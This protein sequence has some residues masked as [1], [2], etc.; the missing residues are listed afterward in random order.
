MAHYEQQQFCTKIRDSFPSYF[1]KK[2]VLDIG[3]LDINGNNRFL[4]DQCNYIGLDVG[5]GSNVDVV[6]V[7]HLYDAPNEQ[8][9]LI[10]STE[11]FE[12]DMY[13]EESVKTWRC[14]PFYLCI[15]WSP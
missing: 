6:K 12:H 7:A 1:S 2:R 11:V 14:I 4:L 3:S 13:Y 10:I 5:E 15:N 9:D 8:F